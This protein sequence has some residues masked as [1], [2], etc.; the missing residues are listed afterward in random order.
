MV[1]QFT[2]QTLQDQCLKTDQSELKEIFLEE[3]GVSHTSVFKSFNEEPIA[4]GSIAQVIRM[5]V[6]LF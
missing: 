3:F 6:S 1:C 4:A 2:F 5:L